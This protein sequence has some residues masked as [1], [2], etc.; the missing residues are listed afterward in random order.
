MNLE[1]LRSRVVLISIVSGSLV[2]SCGDGDTDR[3]TEQA[4]EA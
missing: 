4:R 2:N 3:D 1:I